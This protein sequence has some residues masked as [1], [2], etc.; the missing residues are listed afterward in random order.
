MLL[1]SRSQDALFLERSDSLRADLQLDFFA[2]N[3]NG[4]FLEVWLPHFLG[5]ALRKADIAAILFAFAG[6][7]TLTHVVSFYSEVYFS[8]F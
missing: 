1:L 8:C 3:N 2:I 7:I 6:N 4:L 5:V